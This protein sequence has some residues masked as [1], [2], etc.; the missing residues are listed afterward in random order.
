MGNTSF[1]PIVQEYPVDVKL[2][3]SFIAILSI[4][5]KTKGIFCGNLQTNPVKCI[6]VNCIYTGGEKF[7]NA[8]SHH[9][10]KGNHHKQPQLNLLFH[11]DHI[12]LR[13]PTLPLY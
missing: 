4:S 12:Y 8:K 1:T 9:P 11:L 3:T 5:L 6:N 10:L 2:S 13:G 7:I